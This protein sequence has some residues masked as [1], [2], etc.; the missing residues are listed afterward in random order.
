M[1]RSL[2]RSGQQHRRWEAGRMHLARQA[3]S[4]LA[5]GLRRR[6]IAMIDGAVEQLL[7]PL[8]VLIAA[9]AAA[10]GVAVAIDAALPLLV[11]LASL[12]AIGIYIGA[13]A[14]LV[15]RSPRSLA[16]A[17][18]VAPMY[19]IWKLWTYAR[20]LAVRSDAAWVRTSRD[21]AP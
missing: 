8:S 17:A 9:L 10:L 20:S 11:A 18:S 6:N 5:L 1:A 2:S 12:A 21:D 14:W 7:P 4:L 13:G 16:L 15:A 19:M 3:V